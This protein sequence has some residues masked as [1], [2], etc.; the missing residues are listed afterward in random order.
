MSLKNII[1]LIEHYDQCTLA[2]YLEVNFYQ[3]KKINRDED[4][5][6]AKEDAER[7]R[8]LKIGET[9]VLPY[10]MGTAIKRIQ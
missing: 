8:D 10:A 4:N 6:I 3:R 5:K 1:L 7:V 2:D 9:V